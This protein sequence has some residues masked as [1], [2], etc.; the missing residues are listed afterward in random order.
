MENYG[1]WG[2]GE[3]G[4]ASWKGRVWN[5]WVIM[6]RIQ[7]WAWGGWAEIW[8][9]AEVGDIC[10]LPASNCVALPPLWEEGPCLPGLP[11]K[12]LMG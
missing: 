5:K 8:D 4:P 10:W 2:W 7:E 12:S 3:L 11:G 6:D 1:G 9:M